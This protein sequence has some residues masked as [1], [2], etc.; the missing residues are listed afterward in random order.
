MDSAANQLLK[1]RFDITFAKFYV[2]TILGSCEPTTQANLAKI[3]GQ[4]A[5]AVSNSIAIL[6]KDGL[7]TVSVDPSHKRKNVVN[8]TETGSK[9]VEEASVFLEEQFFEAING[10]KVDIRSYIRDTLILRDSLENS[11]RNYIK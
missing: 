10:V 11:M 2:L 9:L 4:S 7:V 1:Q 6:E 8:L 3:L 5:A